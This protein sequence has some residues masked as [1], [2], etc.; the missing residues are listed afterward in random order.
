MQPL[1]LFNRGRSIPVEGKT[2]EELVA[3]VKVL[4]PEKRAKKRKKLLRVFLC[5]PWRPLWS[6]IGTM[7][8]LW[9]K[10]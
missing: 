5:E 10:V 9:F 2:P 6:A 7:R 8:S 4:V 1:L 3:Q